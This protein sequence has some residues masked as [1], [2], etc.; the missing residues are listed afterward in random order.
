M[1]T[2]YKSDIVPDYLRKATLRNREGVLDAPP[3]WPYQSLFPL[4]SSRVRI[5]ADVVRKII[6]LAKT[7]PIVYAMKYPSLYD[8]HFLR[9]RFAQ[10][11]LPA[12]AFV[13]EMS[14]GVGSVAKFFKVWTK[15]V[16]GMWRE[17]KLLASFDED[18]LTQ[19]FSHGG[20]AV[21]FLVD[22]KASHTRF[23]HPERDPI[24]R[25]LDLQSKIGSCISIVPMMILC[26]RAQRAS[27]RP[28][29]ERLLGD[30]DRPGALRRIHTAL[31]KWMVPELLVGEPVHLL[32]QFEGCGADKPREELPIDV[33]KELIASIDVRIRVN[34]GPEKLSPA[35][36]KERV[37]QD[38]RVQQAVCELVAEKGLPEAKVRKK[39]E[40]YVDEIA[41][42]TSI[43]MYHLLYITLQRIFSRIFSGIDVKENQFAALKRANMGG[44]LVFVSCHKSHFD[45]LLVG[46]LC[47]MNNMA[48]PLMA[49]GQNLAFWPVGP[50]LRHG[51]AF[52]LRRTFKGLRMY[53]E[54]FAAYVKALV[55]DHTNIKFFIEGGRSRTGK[56]LPPKVGLLGF[57]LQAIDERAVPDL[58][59]VPTFVGYDRIP[60]EKSFLKELSGNE[61]SKETFLDVIQARKI[62]SQC[63]GRVYLRFHD[64]ISFTEFRKKWKS[65]IGSASGSVGSRQLLNDFANYLMRGIAKAGVVTPIELAAAG[66]V[67]H[68]KRRVS[69]T[70]FLDAVGCLSDALS[71]QGI[72]FDDRLADRDSALDNALAGFSARGFVKAE[73]DGNT[74][75]PHGYVIEAK[76]KGNLEFYKNSLVNT[77]W[78]VSLLGVSLAGRGP[79]A[80]HTSAVIKEDFRF[81]ADLL[82]KE[83]ILDP[84]ST[85]D[86]AM[87]ESVRLFSECGWLEPDHGCLQ[88]RRFAPV[89]CFRG[90][91]A[92]L[93]L[94]YHAVLVAAENIPAGEI[95]QKDFMKE[96]AKV[97]AEI[98]TD[99]AN[100][101]AAS[102]PSV[103][104]SNAL[105][106]FSDTGILDYNQQR[107]VLISV[108]NMEKL[109]ET[110]QTLARSLRGRIDA[111]A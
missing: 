35:E 48:I 58:A 2:V 12:P 23:I 38:P 99:D 42:K 73:A 18:V 72:D 105:A 6:E 27:S 32:G 80:S 69:R 107:K 87:E 26:D 36:I 24:R 86:D 102:L 5:D 8:L 52:F 100:L 55:K 28:A 7:G 14:S 106:K 111:P 76:T 61:K 50:I 103:T 30:P 60:E 78:H 79:E 53:G 95:N 46:V 75:D 22:E 17:R 13:F 101:G 20:A 91:L 4:L 88:A 97:A 41:N 16:S 47:F 1:D 67:C 49:A 40:A 96:L 45:Y 39:A 84:L 43:H 62:L 10:L 89:E 74:T 44:T 21:M 9:V 110:R 56:L 68:G 94:V 71:K 85:I 25:L 92:D 33:R 82:S 90:I 66:L 11:G 37:L 54:V 64:P 34:R 15:R 81:L 3:P 70:D 109:R 108:N 65:A 57:L 59:F 51:A 29:W 98:N 31:R 19:I 104:V 63:Y 77:L 83:V 93:L